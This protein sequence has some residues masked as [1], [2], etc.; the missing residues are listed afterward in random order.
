MRLELLG[1]FEVLA[2]ADGERGCEVAASERPDIILMDLEKPIINTWEATGRLKSQPQTRDIPVIAHVPASVHPLAVGRRPAVA[3][4]SQ[5]CLRDA[6][7][8]D[9]F[10][11]FA[12]NCM[13]M[14]GAKMIATVSA[15][16]GVTQRALKW[17]ATLSLFAVAFLA[18]DA[19]N[20]Q[21][22]G[23]LHPVTLAPLSHP[24]DPNMLAKELFARKCDAGAD[25]STLNR[26]LFQ[27][28]P[29]RWRGVADQR[30]ELASDAALAQSQLG[31]STLG[32]VPRATCRP[33]VERPAGA[34]SSLATCRNREVARCWLDT[35]AI[36]SV[37]TPISGSCLCPPASSPGWNGNR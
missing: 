34:G 36:R 35:P 15:M 16:A 32:G 10:S 37:S 21:D 2:A 9:A 1:D 7:R 5:Y 8:T 20:A 12:Q 30:Q 11:P 18:C 23:T 17:Y 28:L 3:V 33:G 31:T 6:L 27:G 19:A 26:V 13:R 14:D 25:A 24:D 4:L 29:C 22:K